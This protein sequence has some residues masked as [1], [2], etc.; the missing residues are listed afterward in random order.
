M[1]D[2][3]T[4]KVENNFHYFYSNTHNLFSYIP[5]NKKSELPQDKYHF[6]N[7]I[8]TFLDLQV[9]FQSIVIQKKSK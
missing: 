4:I 7:K 5:T 2:L 6:L 8:I 1:N 9:I 3:K